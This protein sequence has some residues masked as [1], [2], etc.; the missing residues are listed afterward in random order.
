MANACV[1]YADHQG[2]PGNGQGAYGTRHNQT[3]NPIRLD[4]V[5]F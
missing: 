5:R 1:M 2:L 3:K 4:G